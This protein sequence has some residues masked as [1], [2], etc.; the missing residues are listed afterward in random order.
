MNEWLCV[1]QNAIA[2]QLNAGAAATST[3]TAGSGGTIKKV[4]VPVCFISCGL[5]KMQAK[6]S[7]D[8]E[9]EKR[10]NLEG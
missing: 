4:L 3:S 6:A 7:V 5:C 8:E 10:R 9:E 1:I 2:A